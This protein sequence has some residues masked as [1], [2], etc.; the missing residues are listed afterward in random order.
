MALA[1]LDAVY[2]Y[3]CFLCKDAARAED[4]VQDVY[5]KALHAPTSDAF[6]FRDAGMRAWLFTI[7][8]NTYFRSVERDHLARRA[9][10]L[11]AEI[12]PADAPDTVAIER[13]DWS[14]AEPRLNRALGQMSDELAEVLWLWA[15]EGLKYREIAI[16]LD[17]PIGTVMS[18]LHRARTHAA[19]ALTDA[20]AEHT[21]ANDSISRPKSAGEAR[22]A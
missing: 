6:E 4:L 20:I 13:I 7:A 3:A 16:A 12:D 8:R 10:R 22:H 5:S 19:R 21:P 11:T 1:E 14:T 9:L 17:T 18:R 15:V 2:R